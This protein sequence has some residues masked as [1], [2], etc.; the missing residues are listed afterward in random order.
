MIDVL[1]LGELNADLILRG[2][3]APAWGQTEKL[4][5]TPP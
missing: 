3:V 2:D 1:V 5:T 4:M